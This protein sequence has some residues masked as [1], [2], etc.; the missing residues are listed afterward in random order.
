MPFVTSPRPVWSSMLVIF[1]TLKCN[2]LSVLCAEFLTV[3]FRYLWSSPSP[4]L[5]VI[6]EEQFLPLGGEHYDYCVPLEPTSYKLVI[7]KL[8][9]WIP[10]M[11]SLATLTFLQYSTQL[12]RF[13]SG[14]WNT[15]TGNNVACWEEDPVQNWSASHCTWWVG[16]QLC[17]TTE[18]YCF[19]CWT[20]AAHPSC[21]ISAESQARKCCYTPSA[22]VSPTSPEELAPCSSLWQLM[23]YCL[24]SKVLELSDSHHLTQG[25]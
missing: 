16:G 5:E 17:T 11:A 22:L 2:L 23:D 13:S 8:Q 21:A 19:T 25:L 12:P 6:P 7:I 4:S 18:N 20:W 3:S 9:K 15:N 14:K 24:G 10:N 1:F